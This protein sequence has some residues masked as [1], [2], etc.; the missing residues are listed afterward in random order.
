ML[1]PSGSILY[2]RD[3]FQQSEIVHYA[4][5]IYFY[6]QMRKSNQIASIFVFCFLIYWILVLDLVL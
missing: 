3:I 2:A 1:E 5:R 4:Q 6:W